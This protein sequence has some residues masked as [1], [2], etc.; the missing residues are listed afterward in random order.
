[1]F[2]IDVTKNAMMIR[3]TMKFPDSRGRGGRGART[4]RWQAGES[5]QICAWMV[6]EWQVAIFWP[7]V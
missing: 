2:V 7:V 3:P 4:T 1:M 5:A 6:G